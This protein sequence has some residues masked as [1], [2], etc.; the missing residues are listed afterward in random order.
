M[1]LCFII[2]VAGSSRPDTGCFFSITEGERALNGTTAEDISSPLVF[3]STVRNFHFSKH[4][5]LETGSEGNFFQKPVTNP[6]SN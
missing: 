5:I 4:S 6:F 3:L 1:T 2:S